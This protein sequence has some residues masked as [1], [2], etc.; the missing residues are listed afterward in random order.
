MIKRFPPANFYDKKF[1]EVL[2]EAEKEDGIVLGSFQVVR[3]EPGKWY[4]IEDANGEHHIVKNDSTNYF[5]SKDKGL[6]GRL[7]IAKVFWESTEEELF[8]ETFSPYPVD[9]L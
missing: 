2:K 8:A 9:K 1:S 7:N 6:P 3:F 5:I 4:A